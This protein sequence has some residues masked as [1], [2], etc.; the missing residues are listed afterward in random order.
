MPAKTNSCLAT[1]PE[2]FA[3]GSAFAPVAE[4]SQ[5]SDLCAKVEVVIHWFTGDKA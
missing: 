1:S 5:A 4:Q 3:T 2:P